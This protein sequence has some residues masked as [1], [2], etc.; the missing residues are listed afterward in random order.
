MS[1]STKKQRIDRLLVER[2]LASSRHKAQA[3]ILAG[4]V[5]ANDTPIEKAGEMVS[6]DIS[7]RLRSEPQQFVG[8]GGNKI[9]PIFEELNVSLE[10]KVAIDVGASTGGFTDSML[11]R[12]AA[13]VYAVDVGYNQLDHRIRTDSRVVVM[14]RTNARDLERD[15]FDPL[16]S[17]LTMDVSFIGVRKLLSSVVQVLDRPASLMILVKPQFELEREYIAKGGVV[18]DPKHQ[19]L[20]IEYVAKEIQRLGFIVFATCASPLRGEKKGNQE[21]FIYAADEPIPGK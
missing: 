14:E 21:Y 7:I 8:R 4:E 20:A 5:L 10:G 1:K 9:D 12:G 15:M 19:E 6:E 13:K 2:G 18:K 11:Q 3:L 17:F 16:P